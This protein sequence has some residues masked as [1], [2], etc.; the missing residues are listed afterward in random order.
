MNVKKIEHTIYR[1]V[2]AIKGIDGILELIGSFFV[3]VF[4]S[5]FIYRIVQ[6]VFN[7]ELATDPDDYI[8][9]YLLQASQS[10]SLGRKF[11]V[12][13]YLF[14]H[15]V[16]KIGLVYALLSKN[17]RLYI[18]AGGVLGLLVIYQIIRFSFT[19]SL[20]LLA[21]T[22]LDIVI[23]LLIHNEYRRVKKSIKA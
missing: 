22:L 10:L 1:T 11:F 15:G 12:A 9:N 13:F 17:A 8:A 19:H 16:I 18:V 14:I 3:S 4:S 6:I 21:L 2:V 7:H 5:R 20:V 23:L